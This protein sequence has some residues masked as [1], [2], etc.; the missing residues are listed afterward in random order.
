M[1]P[2][3]LAIIVLLGFQIRELGLYKA[4]RMGATFDEFAWTWQGMNLI[5]NKVPTSWSPHPQYKNAKV[6]KHLHTKIRLVT[7][8]LEHPPGFGLVAG[9][10]VMSNGVHDMLDVRIFNFR[11]LALILGTI[12]ILLVYIYAK[13]L[14]G[15]SLGL[16]AALLYAIV[17]TVAIGSR[18]LQN[19]NFFIPIWLFGLILVQNNVRKRKAIIGYL[20]CVIAAFLVFCKVPFMAGGVSFIAL[21]L[22]NKMY[23]EAI[24][25]GVG[26]AIGILLYVS[27]GFYFDKD[28]FLGLLQL[29]TQRYDLTFSNIFSLFEKPFLADRFYTDGWIIW[30]WFSFILLI[31][32]RIKNSSFVILPLLTYLGIYIAGIPDESG[33]GWYRYPMYPFLIISIALFFKEY[34]IKNAVL[35]FMFFAVVGSSLLQN[36]YASLFGFS[37]MVFRIFIALWAAMLLPYFYKNKKAFLISKYIALF[38]LAIY[39]FSSILSII[40][41]YDG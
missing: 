10:Y 18:L 3:L 32:K 37:F 14:F 12:S 35:T 21:Y 1:V 23:K 19:E 8:Y 36:V 34:F 27:Y 30:G 4:P 7:P 15:E 17:P 9:A 13:N 39:I 31:S 33:H 24:L 16:L 29:Q 20:T 11:F 41:F 28:L 5:Q 2:L 40:I 26:V 38:L 25:A 22:Y 6:I